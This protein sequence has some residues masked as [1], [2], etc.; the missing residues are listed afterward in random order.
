MRRYHDWG[1]FEAD[2]AAGRI[3]P[4]DLKACLADA[5]NASA[6]SSGCE[7]KIDSTYSHLALCLWSERRD[8]YT[9]RGYAKAFRA[10]YRALEQSDGDS[11]EQWGTAL[12]R[13][14]LSGTE[15]GVH[16]VNVMEKAEVA[17]THEARLLV[18]MC[19]KT[20]APLEQISEEHELDTDNEAAT[21]L[22]RRAL[23]IW[24]KDSQVSRFLGLGL[25]SQHTARCPLSGA[26]GRLQR[27]KERIRLM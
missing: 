4:W 23:P 14:A 17:A 2:Y 9:M 21:F 20:N 5:L 19:V 13:Y 15:P 10:Y 18:V 25:N 3:H 7:K 8:I 27:L 12:L 24:I 16:L 11:A 6:R 22:V 26:N 1:A